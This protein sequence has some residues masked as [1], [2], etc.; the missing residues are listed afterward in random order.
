MIGE[1]FI[2]NKFNNEP[3]ISLH[4][5]YHD[6]GSLNTEKTNKMHNDI[7]L[8]INKLI[9][10]YK[11]NS[12]NVFIATNKQKLVCNS[13]LKDYY[14]LTVDSNNNELES[15]IEQYICCK[16]LKFLYTGGDLCKPEHK[17]LRSTW[18]SFVLDY[19]YCILNKNKLDHI[20]LTN[21]F[22]N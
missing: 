15:F 19:R 10:E 1:D 7:S 13:V 17:H 22:N 3:Y 5:R 8:L 21:Y 2:K 14:M 12:K 18:V 6:A 20:Y 16:S 9:D 4:L 11:I